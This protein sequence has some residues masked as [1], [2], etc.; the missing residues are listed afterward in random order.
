[1]I[2]QTH[3]D[4]LR[5]V[6]GEVSVVTEGGVDFVFLPHLV[7]PPGCIPRETT[8]LLCVGRHGGYSSARN[9]LRSR[10]LDHENSSPVDLRPRQSEW[11]CDRLTTT[12]ALSFPIIGV[13]HRGT[14]SQTLSPRSECLVT[15]AKPLRHVPDC[16]IDPSFS[17]PF[18]RPARTP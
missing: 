1:M 16:A 17:S 14:Q 11:R 6:C 12:V 15:S 4:E 10:D 13:P 2:D 7:L 5:L 3:L 18:P 8:A 9:R